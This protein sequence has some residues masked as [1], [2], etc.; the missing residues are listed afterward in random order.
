MLCVAPFEREAAQGRPAVGLAGARRQPGPGAQRR[1][2]WG[3][4]TQGG[5]TPTG[6]GRPSVRHV[7]PSE[8]CASGLPSAVGREGAGGS[9]SSPLSAYNFLKTLSSLVCFSSP[10][11]QAGNLQT[12]LRRHSGEKPY[13][14][15]VCGKRSVRA[16]PWPGGS[17]ARSGLFGPASAC[18]RASGGCRAV[19]GPR[20]RPLHR[21]AG[22]PGQ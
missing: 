18:A 20:P 22:R 7:A 6:A 3:R 4:Q 13:I 19:Q 2:S 17:T 12:H 14:C 5:D 1:A 11:L 16:W 9:V 10:L 15:E 8:A 21:P